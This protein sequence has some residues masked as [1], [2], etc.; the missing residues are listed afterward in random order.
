LLDPAESASLRPSF[1]CGVGIARVRLMRPVTRLISIE[2]VCDATAPAKSARFRS[3][4]PRKNHM[5]ESRGSNSVAMR[6]CNNA[7]FCS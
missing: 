2:R 7:S 6:A 3:R 4:T 1:R 5:F